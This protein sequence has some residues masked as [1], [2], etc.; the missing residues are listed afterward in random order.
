MKK[1]ILRLLCLLLS[2]VLLTGALFSCSENEPTDAEPDVTDDDKDDDSKPSSEKISNKT[3]AFQLYEEAKEALKQVDSFTETEIT[4]LDYI[5]NDMRLVSSVSLTALRTGNNSD[6][7]RYRVTGENITTVYNGTEKV[8]EVEQAITQGFENGKMFQ[9]LEMSSADGTPT[10]SK[11]YSNISA[12][13]YWEFMESNA[14]R[15]SSQNCQN[16]SCEQNEDEG[17]TLT[18]SGFDEKII[19]Q[20]VGD[21]F[22]GI[23]ESD[24]QCD[25][26]TLLMTITKDHMPMMMDLECSFSS[27]DPE[28]TNASLPKL[29]ITSSIK[30]INDTQAPAAM[31][32]SGYRNVDDLR[33]PTLLDQALNNYLDS[34]QGAFSMQTNTVSVMGTNQNT[35]SLTHNVSFSNQDEKIS[36]SMEQ[37]NDG[38]TST[39]RYQNN[40]MEIATGTQQTTY[41]Y[42]QQ[43]A[44]AFLF[45]MLHQFDFSAEEI[46]NITVTPKGE[47]STQYLIEQNSSEIVDEIIAEIGGTPTSGTYTLDVTIT[48]GVITAYKYGLIA[49]I[50]YGSQTMELHCICEINFHTAN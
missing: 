27:V 44:R 31:N 26:I 16:A 5:I 25:D 42:S 19:R 1:S 10:T 49:L 12:A 15:F 37:I 32:F 47:N 6:Q 45:S 23:F 40:D 4:S 14:L 33:V 50:S 39:F 34:D 18:F 41:K 48:D 46:E 13:D 28:N 17:W 2:L 38:V 35:S 24:I 20:L 30:D 8:S 36:Y 22:D 11:L 9:A 29:S 3:L 21:F 7:L 43:A